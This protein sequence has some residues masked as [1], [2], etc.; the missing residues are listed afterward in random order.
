MKKYIIFILVSI[1]ST[2]TRAQSN[3]MILFDDI[4]INTFNLNQTV[5]S[6]ISINGYPS[7]MNNYYNELEDETWLELKYGQN[8]FYFLNNNLV[9][10]ELKDGSFYLNY[11]F[12]KV[13][14]VIDNIN[15][16]FA[17]SFSQREVL[18]YVGF[19]TLDI[20]MPDGTITDTSIVILYDPPSSKILS[21]QY[22]SN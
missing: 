5:S 3:D 7:S 19:I 11:P 16:V 2:S 10:F 9:S 13:G 14:N 15:S 20:G 22:V 6:L 4:K 1:V 21:I 12:I 8:S 18:N 17:N